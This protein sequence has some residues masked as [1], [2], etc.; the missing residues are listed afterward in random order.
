MDDLSDLEL[1]VLHAIAVQ[2]SGSTAVLEHQMKTA[3]AIARENTGAGFF[4]TFT[5]AS[6]QILEGVRSPVGDVGATVQGLKHGMGF[7]LWIKDGLM[8]QLE[9]YANGD[10]DTSGLDFD[11]VDFGNVEPR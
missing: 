1:A 7:L 10:E 4:T 5:V 2:V 3:R 9:G 8:Y 11:R 6:D